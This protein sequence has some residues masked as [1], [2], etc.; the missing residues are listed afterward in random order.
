MVIAYP[1]RW[2]RPAV[3]RTSEREGGNGRRVER[4]PHADAGQ[5][6]MRYLH[7]SATTFI[8]ST[9]ITGG[10]SGF[11]PPAAPSSAGGAFGCCTGPVTSIFLLTLVFQSNCGDV[12]S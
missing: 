12:P 2:R 8:D 7:V 6:R 9:C 1:N 4:L 10:R 3:S 5:T 11:A